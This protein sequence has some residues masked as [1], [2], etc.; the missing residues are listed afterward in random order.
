MSSFQYSQDALATALIP[1]SSRRLNRAAIAGCADA[2]HLPAN[3]GLALAEVVQPGGNQLLTL[4]DG[5]N[6]RLG[7][8]DRLIVALGSPYAPL[9]RTGR[10]PTELGECD[11]LTAS[12]VAG[13]EVARMQTLGRATQ[14]RLLGL[15]ADASGRAL[16]LTDFALPALASQQRPLRS[17]LVIST[18]RRTQTS[19]AM[20]SLLQG[21]ARQAPVAALQLTGLMDDEFTSRL[22]RAGARAVLDVNDV[23]H[24][25]ASGLSDVTL[26]SVADQ[27][28]GHA[29]ASGATV[30][31][32][33]LA[34]GLAQREVRALL[35]SPGFA[36]R[37]DGALLTA[38]D[39][40][41]AR[42]GVRALEAAG[43]PVLAVSGSIC[44]SPLAMREAQP[45]PCPLL[46]PDALFAD[47]ADARW[48]GAP[49]LA[50]TA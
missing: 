29:A 25:T 31:I 36:Q 49:L 37:F 41:S 39:A 18:A 48:F 6:H 3:G 38:A 1:Y 22:Q 21:L 35:T 44:A 47:A 20:L 12:G 23:G 2:T 34:G 33:R 46:P 16:N 9:A 43:V 15:L 40:L 7:K 10:I 50:L 28:L 8:G 5:R 45:L 42:A 13:I 32:T 19:P 24:P 17:L 26:L 4:A 27:L 30:S 11:L 14:L